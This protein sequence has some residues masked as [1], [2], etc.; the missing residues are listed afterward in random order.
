MNMQIDSTALYIEKDEL[1]DLLKKAYEEGSFG[2]LDLKD[3]TAGRILEEY[4]L[5]RKDKVPPLPGKF[6]AYPYDL[7]INRTGIQIGIDTGIS[8]IQIA[9]APS[10]VSFDYV[11]NPVT[12]TTG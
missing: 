1:L 8:G 6:E 5:E 3:A 12:I 9:S 7:E 2:Y 10:V 4:L 11:G